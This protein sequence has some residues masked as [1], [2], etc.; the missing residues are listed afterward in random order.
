MTAVTFLKTFSTTANNVMTS[1]W[2][3]EDGCFFV[4]C[5]FKPLLDQKTLSQNSHRSL[6]F[7]WW[8]TFN[9]WNYF[10]IHFSSFWNISAQIT[11][12]ITAKSSTYKKPL[13]P[14]AI[15]Q[16]CYGSAVS[17]KMFWIYYKNGPCFQTIF[18]SYGYDH[19]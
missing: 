3:L 11:V 10:E 12:V 1:A 4:I 7:L 15:F 19:T 6:L 16:F 8:H 9:T 13:L 18:R 2:L 5:L 17:F 14:E